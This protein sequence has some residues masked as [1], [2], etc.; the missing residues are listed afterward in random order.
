[1][2]IRPTVGPKIFSTKLHLVLER[3]SSLPYLGVRLSEPLK[4]EDHVNLIAAKASSTLAFLR[5]SLKACPSK[6]KEIA[7][8]AMVRSPLEYSSAVWEP[9]HF[10]M[11][12]YGRE[13]SVSEMLTTLC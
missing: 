4:W 13:S 5:R 9:A 12:Q 8:F 6:L 11:Q 1:M 10:V 2:D 7:S 3:V